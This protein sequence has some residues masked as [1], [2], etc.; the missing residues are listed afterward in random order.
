[1]KRLAKLWQ[2]DAGMPA[3]EP[4]RASPSAA[5][6]SEDLSAAF[7][8]RMF[9]DAHDQQDAAD[10]H[11][12]PIDATASALP[13]LDV[14]TLV[15]QHIGTATTSN[16]DLQARVDQALVAALPAFRLAEPTLQAD[17][18][19]IHGIDV[20]DLV[21]LRT[22][23]QR[24]VLVCIVPIMHCLPPRYPCL[25]CATYVYSRPVFSVVCV[26]LHRIKCITN[27]P[28]WTTTSLMNAMQVA[29][30]A[31]DR[32]TARR[33]LQHLCH[34]RLPPEADL[35]RNSC[36]QVFTVLQL[37]VQRLCMQNAHAAV[38]LRHMTEAAFAQHA[39]L[40]VLHAY[41]QASVQCVADSARGSN[42]PLG[43]DGPFRDDAGPHTPQES[44][45]QAGPASTALQA[46]T[47]LLDG[48]IAAGITGVWRTPA[49]NADGEH[50]SSK[51]QKSGHGQ[52]TPFPASM[53]HGNDA[54][55][56]IQWPPG[57]E[58]CAAAHA[59]AAAA[60]QHVQLVAMQLEV[61][62]QHSN[63]LAGASRCAILACACPACM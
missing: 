63:L 54:A 57:E 27:F 1:M 19:F 61:R 45:R 29:A 20:P 46:I 2:R 21:R 14:L 40:A 16:Q 18:C 62:E 12:H 59:K 11:S 53:C 15:H 7:L 30:G 24:D 33:A 13:A 48:A 5:R 42:L 9:Q 47:K 51:L 4:G 56:K 26:Y 52:A 6:V 35:T 10:V 49:V 50:K 22:A 44:G 41:V 25:M 43:A 17:W 60:L 23:F 37:A 31:W 34:M 58:Q 28:I 36:E 38:L 8:Q 39:H 3:R 32:V 55:N